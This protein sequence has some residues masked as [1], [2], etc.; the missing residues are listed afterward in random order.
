MIIFLLKDRI[1]P[2]VQNSQSIPIAYGRGCCNVS[3]IKFLQNYSEHIFENVAVFVLDFLQSISRTSESSDL[4]SLDP[5]LFDI[6]S[7]SHLSFV[8]S[9]QTSYSENTT[10]FSVIKSYLNVLDFLF[11]FQKTYTDIDL[12][13][14]GYLIIE[15]KLTNLW[16]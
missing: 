2:A 9:E 1:F 4:C 7:S 12:E 8:V 6:L 16:D 11:E 15:Y 3:R 14:F 5:I 10:L 13:N